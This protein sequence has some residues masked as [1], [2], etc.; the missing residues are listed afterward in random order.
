MRPDPLCPIC[1]HDMRRM[2]PDATLELSGHEMMTFEVWECMS[3][4]G[5]CTGGTTV[6]FRRARHG[7]EAA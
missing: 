1:G 5:R 4:K 3:D 2:S 7:E 6:H